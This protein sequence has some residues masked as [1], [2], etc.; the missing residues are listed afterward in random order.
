VT[1]S[2]PG[3][4]S[5]P[6]LTGVGL[7]PGAP[8]LITL[9]GL[10]AIE[11]AGVIFAPTRRPGERSR[12]LEGA[13][14]L[15]DLAGREVI[16]IPFPPEDT[17][18]G[19]P[20]RADLVA[21]ALSD[22]RRGVLLTEGDPAFYSSFAHVAA[23]LR[24]RHPTI[25]VEIVPGISSISASAAAIGTGLA[26][27]AE[28]IAVIPATATLGGLEEILTAFECVVLLKVGPVLRQLIE[29]LERLGM[30]GRATYVRRCS[31]H[32]EEIVRDL[33]SLGEDPP[34]DYWALVVVRRRGQ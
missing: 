9:R 28:R 1:L 33:S 34:R 25:E 22:D 8:D 15:V 18:G 5:R 16:E 24:E 30:L 11:A 14:A 26:E 23:A 2:G 32:D 6:L 20:E 29:L 12:A 19:W 31:R 10:R 27:H 4:R 21:S 13:T 17:A 3:R 7:G